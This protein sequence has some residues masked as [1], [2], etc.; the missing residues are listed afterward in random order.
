MLGIMEAQGYGSI[1][2][3]HKALYQDTLGPVVAL[4]EGEIER[5]LLVEFSD[6]EDIYVQANINEKLQGSF[7]EEQ[8]ALVAATGS[9]YMARNEARARLNL[10]RI[11]SAA[12]DVPVTRL[13]IAEG[14]QA[15]RR[16]RREDAMSRF[17]LEEDAPDDA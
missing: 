7:E 3:Q 12:F 4:I 1:R 5:Q 17:A 13:D 2:E 14:Q 16:A 10:P 9:P 15:K 11:N 8:Q 6:S